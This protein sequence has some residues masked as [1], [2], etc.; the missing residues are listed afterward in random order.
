MS[1]STW[2]FLV[3]TYAGNEAE[4]G[5]KIYL[6]G[7]Q[8]DDSSASTGSYVAMEDTAAGVG[9]GCMFD[10]YPAGMAFFNGKMGAVGVCAKE[11][12]ASEVWQLSALVRGHFGV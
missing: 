9:I 4:G 8:V 2:Y 6:D 3:G 10:T 12:S 7:T 1:T 11:L 5:I